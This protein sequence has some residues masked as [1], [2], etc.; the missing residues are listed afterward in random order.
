MEKKK[1]GVPHET[2]L[3]FAGKLTQIWCECLKC[4]FATHCGAHE[5]GGDVKE[6]ERKLCMSGILQGEVVSNQGLSDR[7]QSGG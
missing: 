5:C 3:A 1:G 6:E 2:S 4:I 7:Q